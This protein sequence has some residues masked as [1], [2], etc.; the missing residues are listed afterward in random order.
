MRRALLMLGALGCLAGWGMSPA[1]RAQTPQGP[2][3]Q[4]GPAAV[5]G[6]ALSGNLVLYTSQLEADAAQTVEAFRRLHPGVQVEWLRGGTGQ[7]L[8]RLRAEIAAGRPRADVLL[9]ADALT[10]EALGAEGRLRESPE[11]QLGQVP[12]ELQD[13]RRRYFATKLITTGIVYNTRAP[14]VPARWTDLL[15]PEARNLVA[16]PSPTVS[17]AAALHVQAWA[18]NNALGWDYV[19]KLASAGL[20]P[21]GGNGQVLQAVASGERAYGVA[22]DY[23][24]IR[25]TARGAPVKFVFPEEGV[26][27]VTEPAAILSTAQNVPAAVAFVSFLLSR[28]GQEL[29]SRQGFLPADPGVQPPPGFPDANSIRLLPLDAA[30]AAR[31]GEENLRRFNALV[32]Q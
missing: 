13:S 15:R 12:A 3:G 22:V 23:L 27:A 30:R 29:A 11:V 9:L 19:G 32:G 26:S 8:P 7:I 1:A 16:M 21:R 31:E 28:E 6:S 24:A 10:F 4:P 2:A 17:G 5:G 25:E 20:Q 14:F 18:Q